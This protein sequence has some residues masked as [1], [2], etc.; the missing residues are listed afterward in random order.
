M[1]PEQVAGEPVDGRCDLYALGCVLYQLLTGSCPFEGTSGVAIMGKQLRDVPDAP[2]TVARDRVIPAMVEA[3]VMRALEKG[4]EDRFAN[5]KEMREA[6][7]A[8]VSRADR[9]RGVGKALVGLAG[10]ASL[11]IL[12]AGG[13][14]YAKET[15]GR[16]AAFAGAIPTITVDSLP[17]VP[18]ET[19]PTPPPAA[20]VAVED[21]PKVERDAPG[22]Q[23]PVEGPK[24]AQAKDAPSEPGRKT[25][26][27]S[28]TEPRSA[29]P[30]APTTGAPASEPPPERG[31]EAKAA[32]KE[33]EETAPEAPAKTEPP[34]LLRH[35]TVRE[36]SHADAIADLD[37]KRRDAE[38]HPQDPKALRAWA[39]A[40]Y[41]AHD[42]KEA[43]RAAREW[44]AHDGSAEPRVFLATVLEASGHRTEAKS[45]IDEW[46]SRHPDSAEARRMRARLGGERKPSRR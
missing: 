27:A 9:R 34:A 18:G 36:S 22:T 35:A 11:A 33:Q 41:R 20:S 13:A 23:A 10:L 28:A 5:A 29:A 6:L 40:A 17:L 21:L 14:N 44:A 12:L 26:T 37:A 3:V 39:K 4:R 2:S 25:A 1:S 42:T 16:K 45:V 32:A 30:R 19:P 38:A 31:E 15:R 43:R 24:L 7:E 46:I 8:A